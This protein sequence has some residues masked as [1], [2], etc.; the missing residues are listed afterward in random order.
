LLAVA[1]LATSATP[2]AAH[3]APPGCVT[4]DLQLTVT[5]DRPVVR[6]GEDVTFAVRASNNSPGACH[7][8][9]ATITLQLPNANGSVIQ[10][11][12]ET[13]TL[14][15]TGAYDA[16][17]SN[18]LVGTVTYEAKL[19]AGVTALG[20]VAK[21]SYTAHT[22]TPDTTG[23]TERPFSVTVS[24][25]SLSLT[26]TPPAGG[27][28]P[29]A[30]TI[31]Y[32][33]RN[34]SSTP[35]S[36]SAVTILDGGCQGVTRTSAD[37]NNL[38]D[39]DETWQFSCQRTFTLPSTVN[40]TVVANAV[41]ADDGRPVNAPN[42]SWSLTA[43]PPPR[44]RITLDQIVDPVTGVAPFAFTHTYTVTNVSEAEAKPVTDVA[45][46][47]PACTPATVV[48]PDAQL[49]RGEQ[50][51]FTCRSQLSAAGMISSSAIASG[52][53]SFDGAAIFSNL[54]PASVTG[55]AAPLASEPAPTPTPTPTPDVSPQNVTPT[56]SANVRFAYTG[57]F[58]PARSC[59][60]TVTLTLKAGAKTVATKKVKLDRKC[61]YKVSITVARVKL[62]TATKV[63][64][65][66]KAKGKRSSSR[67]LN[68]PKT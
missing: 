1:L 30:A 25:P 8:T 15:T 11:G 38:L 57:R 12:G 32:A 21:A 10:P 55:T 62:G 67:R 65:T 29:L 17:T 9:D 16:A 35:T 68:V 49:T 52:K 50:L 22:G 2:A 45:I 3:Q 61:R 37:A 39:R 5:A 19:N 44:P 43:S 51:T 33:V 4:R 13:K 26:A 27:I 23:T 60:G 66:A 34:T 56:P 58:R 6:A 63:T 53:D 14:T 59:K 20:V 28:V 46:D 36:M 41:S 18:A 42:A 24:Q 31:T 40:A 47:D 54:S 48:T 7:V 64:V